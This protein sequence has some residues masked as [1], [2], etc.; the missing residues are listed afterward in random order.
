MLFAWSPQQACGRTD[1]KE[2]GWH[3]IVD[4][5]LEAGI[6]GAPLLPCLQSVRTAYVLPHLGLSLIDPEGDMLVS[7]RGTPLHGVP[8]SSGQM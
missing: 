6:P 2:P 1:F 3:T 4:T 8:L 7:L 5:Q